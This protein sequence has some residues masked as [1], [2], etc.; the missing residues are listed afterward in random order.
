M[1]ATV[2]DR[3]EKDKLSPQKADDYFSFLYMFL[4]EKTD[5]DLSDA[6]QDLLMEGML[7]H[8]WGTP[9]APDPSLMRELSGRILKQ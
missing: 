5:V 7:F 6:A 8:D 9:F 4:D 3:V 1:S 2:L